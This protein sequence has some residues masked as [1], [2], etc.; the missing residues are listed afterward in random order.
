M[1]VMNPPKNTSILLR[2][3]RVLSNGPTAVSLA[4]AFWDFF[5]AVARLAGPFSRCPRLVVLAPVSGHKA[6]CFGRWEIQRR[7][8]IKK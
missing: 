1:Y 5:K 3:E 6:A 4:F 7:E 2:F 8:K